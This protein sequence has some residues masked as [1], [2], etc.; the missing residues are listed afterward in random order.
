[1]TW[2]DAHD[3]CEWAGLRLPTEAEWEK[4]ARGADGRR[5]PWG[6]KATTGEGCV[7][8]AHPLYGGESTAPVG[9]AA[10]DVSPCEA[11]DMAGNVMEWCAD[12]YDERVYQRYASRQGDAARRW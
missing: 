7:S 1:V 11:V 5:F 8:E 4:A 6:N 12:F 3:F 10:R 2:D 9:S